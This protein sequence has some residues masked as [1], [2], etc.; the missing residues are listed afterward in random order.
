MS[1]RL[2]QWTRI[3]GLWRRFSPSV[4]CCVGAEGMSWCTNSRR[5][6]LCLLSVSTWTLR[7]QVTTSWLVFLFAPYFPCSLRASSLLSVLVHHTEWDVSSDF[8]SLHK[9]GKVIREL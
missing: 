3:L 6:L 1:T 9:L 8:V 7:G 4:K 2:A 5:K